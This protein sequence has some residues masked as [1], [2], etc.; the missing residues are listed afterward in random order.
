MNQEIAILKIQR[1]WKKYLSV[2]LCPRCHFRKRDFCPE[3]N[4]CYD[5]YEWR[6]SD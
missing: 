5:C 2:S 3:I 4:K 1:Y 6:H